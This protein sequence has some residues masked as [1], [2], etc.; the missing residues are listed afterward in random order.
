MPLVPPTVVPFNTLAHGEAGNASYHSPRMTAAESAAGAGARLEVAVEGVSKWTKE[1]T[2]PQ[3]LR[4]WPKK[5]QS[6]MGHS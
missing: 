1:C 4:T 2:A 6:E 5:F 3:P